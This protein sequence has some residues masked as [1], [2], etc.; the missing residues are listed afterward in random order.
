MPRLALFD[1]DNT[2]ID[3]AE[4]AFHTAIGQFAA[5]QG[6]NDDDLH[7]LTVDAVHFWDGKEGEYFNEVVKRFKLADD[8][9]ELYQ[10]YRSRYLASIRPMN[11]VI[12]GLAAL[13]QAGWR[14]AIVTN[15]HSS[16]QLARMNQVGLGELADAVC[17]AE[18]EESWKPDDRIFRRAAEKAGATL[19]DAWM[20]GD[21]LDADIVGGANLG[22]TTVWISH[23][24]SLPAE[25]P[26]PTYTLTETAEVFTLIL[27]DR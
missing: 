24:R 6:L 27:N 22:L 8:P 20:T 12:S 15:G 21:S 5:E 13:R 10:V 16:V 7:W 1:L 2:L 9:L 19:D 18:A 14:T 26:V 11:G 3:P 25:G 4:V 23:G 17:I